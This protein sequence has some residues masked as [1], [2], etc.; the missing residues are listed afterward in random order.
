[1]KADV[2]NIVSDVMHWVIIILSVLLIVYISVDTFQGVNFLK[3][4][5]Y[6]TFQLWVCIVFIADF[7]IELAI[8]ENR[9][10]YVRGLLLFLLLTVPY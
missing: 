1:M 4:R 9:W 6:M 2:K 10:R 7:F 8:A 3:N 5:S